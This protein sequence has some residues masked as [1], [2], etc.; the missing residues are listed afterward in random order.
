MKLWGRTTSVNVQK[1]LWA[2]DELELAYE[3]VDA[4]MHFGVVDTPAY[5]ALNPNGKVPVLE[6]GDFV[7]WESHAIVR[8]LARTY[9]KGRLLPADERGLALADQWMDWQAASFQGAMGPAFL[10]FIRTAEPDRNAAVIAKSVAAT[11]SAVALLDDALADRTYILGDAFSMAD[12]PLGAAVARWKKMP[13]E[14]A[15]R[16]NVDRW[17]ESVSARPAFGAYF[18]AVLT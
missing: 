10:G 7:L 4:R 3:Q 1:A 5:R 13:V 12:I 2:L 15:T 9:G 14:R 17:F 8:H 11:E 16:S 18:D 6:D